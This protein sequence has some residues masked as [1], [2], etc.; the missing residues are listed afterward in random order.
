MAEN[1]QSNPGEPTESNEESLTS[2]IEDIVRN[3]RKLTNKKMFE[4]FIEREVMMMESLEEMSLL[5]GM[6]I[7]Y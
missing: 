2:S 3:A 7:E 4:L 5:V 1:V 6:S